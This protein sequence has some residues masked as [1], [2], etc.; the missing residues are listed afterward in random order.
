MDA[1]MW[2]VAH[3]LPNG[4]M[5][6]R[7]LAMQL[8][9]NYFITSKTGSYYTTSSS[10]YTG[11]A[12]GAWHDA[13]NLWNAAIVNSNSAAQNVV[14]QFPVSSGLPT[15]AVKEIKYTSAINDTNEN[16]TLVSI[17]SG[18]AVVAGPNS[19][20]VTITV[21]AYGLVVAQAAAGAAS[22][23]PTASASPTATASASPTASATASATATP[24]PTA[25]ATASP[26]P[27]PSP[28]RTPG[29]HRQRGTTVFN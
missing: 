8:L 27:T 6:P 20:Q 4:L 15:G 19:N 5:R 25:T 29:R 14:V 12:V 26:A 9:N 3:D 11:I 21:P 16:S 23:T 28:T 2:G 13:H 17:G 22:P 18:A 24:S 10:T 1:Q 7:G